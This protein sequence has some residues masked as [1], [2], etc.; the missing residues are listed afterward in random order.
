MSNSMQ[1]P[2]RNSLIAFVDTFCRILFSNTNSAINAKA[3][4]LADLSNKMANTN[5]ARVYHNGICLNPRGHSTSTVGLHH[6]LVEKGDVLLKA[7]R[8]YEIERGY[9]FRHLSKLATF[10]SPE[11][12]RSYFPNQLLDLLAPSLNKEIRNIPYTPL[13]KEDKAYQ[14]IVYYLVDALSDN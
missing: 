4:K 11:E 8:T 10:G 5:G 1:L 6:S 2:Y 9:L 14:I 12:L 13:P 3:E 7:S